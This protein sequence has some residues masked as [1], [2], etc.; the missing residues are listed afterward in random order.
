MPMVMLQKDFF[1][2]NEEKVFVLSSGRIVLPSFVLK[3][4]SIGHFSRCCRVLLVTG[5]VVI[6]YIDRQTD[7]CKQNAVLVV[8]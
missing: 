1:L 3:K 8:F 4:V 2:P 6:A 5:D 7:I